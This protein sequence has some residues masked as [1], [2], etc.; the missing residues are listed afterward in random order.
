VFQAIRELVDEIAPAARPAAEGASASPHMVLGCS[1]RDEVDEVALAMFGNLLR[2]HGRNI[3]VVSSKA[4]IAEV[5]E[6]VSE[7]C[8][9]VVVIASVPPSGLAQTRYVCK[10]LKAQCPGVKVVVGR[11]G[12]QDNI[13][14]MRTRLKDSGADHVGTTLAET[15]AEVIARM[16]VAES[17]RAPEP[18]Q[19]SRE[20]LAS[21]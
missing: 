9:G 16:V 20:L 4:L 3:E 15:R 13:E 17:A 5:L 2:A 18:P 10:R 1:A 11:W 19:A 7:S 14:Q 21:H 6:K 12:S 8:P